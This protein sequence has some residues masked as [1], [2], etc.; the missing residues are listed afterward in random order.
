MPTVVRRQS[1]LEIMRKT[2][3][4]LISKFPIVPKKVRDNVLARFVNGLSKEAF[5][6]SVGYIIG[7]ID[8]N[9][10][11]SREFKNCWEETY[12]ITKRLPKLFEYKQMIYERVKEHRNKY[13][14]PV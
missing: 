5:G 2:P 14:L 13:H 6:I 3:L 12:S 10:K 4:L 1:S 9:K 7:M 8:F 11:D